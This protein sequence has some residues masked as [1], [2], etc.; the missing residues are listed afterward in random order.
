MHT[1]VR[2]ARNEQKMRRNGL[3]FNALIGRCE[4]LKLIVRAIVRSMELHPAVAP[5]QWICLV[6]LTDLHALNATTSSAFFDSSGT[7][8]LYRSALGKVVSWKVR[9]RELAR[10]F[11]V[12]EASNLLSTLS[13][14]VPFSGAS[15]AYL[16]AFG[17]E[18]V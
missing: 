1:V 16:I 2:L 10:A 8:I 11:S 9:A 4:N 3:T 7:Q 12:E 6:C 13:D 5:L 15:S 18:S 17:Y 14:Y